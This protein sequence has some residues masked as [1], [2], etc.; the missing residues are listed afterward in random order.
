MTTGQGDVSAKDALPLPTEVMR[1]SAT[2]QVTGKEESSFLWST[3][4]AKIIDTITNT[5]IFAPPSTP[6]PTPSAS[7]SNPPIPSFDSTKLL[8]LASSLSFVSSH[9]PPPPPQPSSN[10]IVYL[11]GCGETRPSNNFQALASSMSLP[12]TLSLFLLGPHEIPFDL[13]YGWYQSMDYS[14]GDPLPFGHAS[15]SRTFLSSVS[16]VVRLLEGIRDGEGGGS[17]ENVFLLAYA[18][19]ADV[20]M[21]VAGRVKFGGAACFRGGDWEGGRG[22]VTDVLQLLGKDDRRYGV[23]GAGG[24]KVERFVVDADGRMGD[25]KEEITELFKWLAPRLNKRMPKMEQMFGGV[26]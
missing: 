10:L 14:T 9:L 6:Y 22:K 17:L 4:D 25:S 21:E 2:N 1:I 5:L 16:K 15:R 19:G 7:P 24:D 26:K 12:Q 13:G 18:S 11:P 8:S 3:S 23:K 20:A